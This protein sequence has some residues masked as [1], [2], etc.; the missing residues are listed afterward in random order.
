MIARPDAWQN[1]LEIKIDN[2]VN[3]IPAFYQNKVR[4]LS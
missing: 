1:K 3:L 4:V 2:C